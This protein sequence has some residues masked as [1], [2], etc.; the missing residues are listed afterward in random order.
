MAA[1]IQVDGLA[2]DYQMGSTL[3]QALRGVTLEIA[4]GEFVAVMGPSGSG[5]STFM[6]SA[7]L[8]GPTQPWPLP[9]RGAGSLATLRR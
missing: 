3:V 7:G 4:A 9:A 8:S 1:L 5:K 6:N 2:K